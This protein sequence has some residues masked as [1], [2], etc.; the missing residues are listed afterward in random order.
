M[1]IDYGLV[2]R[3]DIEG[4]ASRGWQ[5]HLDARRG[6]LMALAAVANTFKQPW[7]KCRLAEWLGKPVECNDGKYNATMHRWRGADYFVSFSPAEMPA[8]PPRP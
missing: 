6:E 8:T 5:S 3:A 2:S 1:R 7:W 4:A